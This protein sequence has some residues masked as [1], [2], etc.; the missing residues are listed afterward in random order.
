MSYVCWDVPK[1][2]MLKFHYWCQMCVEMFPREE[3]LSST[4]GVICV[5]L[6]CS[7]ETNAKVPLLVSYACWDVPKRRTL[8]FHYLS[9]CLLNKVVL[10]PFKMPAPLQPACLFYYSTTNFINLLHRTMNIRHM[11]GFKTLM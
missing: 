5:L 8:K 4:T 10:L 2:R 3:C 1:R 7:Q 6:R 9:H 11:L